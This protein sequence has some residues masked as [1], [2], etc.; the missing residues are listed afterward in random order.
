M[1]SHAS[2]TKPAAIH[3]MLTALFY[4]AVF[5]TLIALLLTRRGVVVDPSFGLAPAT[6]HFRQGRD[7][8]PG[9]AI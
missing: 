1:F 6:A 5:D 8:A 3:G 7:S 9:E 4:T 2:E